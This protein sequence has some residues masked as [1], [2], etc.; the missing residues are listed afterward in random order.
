MST[1]NPWMWLSLGKVFADVIKLRISK[2]DHPGLSRW[3]LNPVMSVL[4]IE[5]KAETHR[6]QGHVQMEAG[7]GAM[8]LQAK[9][10]W[11]HWKLGEQQ[12]KILPWSSEKEPCLPTR[13]FQT[14]GLQ[15]CE[16][17]KSYCFEPP[18]LW[19]YVTAASGDWDRGPASTGTQTICVLG[20]DACRV[21]L[22]D[23]Q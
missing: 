5:E 9:D 18:S 17:T 8:L 14:S 11:S 16:R 2:W 1:R 20:G 15:Y 22:T 12:E 4:I 19:S 10:A 13:W 23:T 3:A 21:S 7:T 6:G